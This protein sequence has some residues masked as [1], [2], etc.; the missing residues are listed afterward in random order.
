[1]EN[2]LNQ[3]L[4]AIVDRV[5]DLV[6]EL[7]AAEDLNEELLAENEQLRQR[8]VDAQATAPAFGVA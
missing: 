4:T 5:S 6:D 8:L 7:L 2:P 3:R 1:M